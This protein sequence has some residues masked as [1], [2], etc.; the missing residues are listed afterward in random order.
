[1]SPHSDTC[2]P[3]LATQRLTVQ[4]APTPEAQA[5]ARAH[6]G[7]RSAAARQPREAA[8]S[9]TLDPE[10]RPSGRLTAG[11]GKAQRAEPAR[12]LP[13]VALNSATVP[14]DHSEIAPNGAT[15]PRDPGERVA[16][17]GATVPRATGKI[18]PLS[19]ARKISGEES[20]PTGQKKGLLKRT[21]R[22]GGRGPGT[23]AVPTERPRK[24][25]CPREPPARTEPPPSAEGAAPRRAAR[26]APSAV[27]VDEGRSGGRAKTR[28]QRPNGPTPRGTLKQ[29]GK[30]QS[31]TEHSRHPSLPSSARAAQ[32]LSA[33][34]SSPLT[35]QPAAANRSHCPLSV[36]RKD[37]PPAEHEQL[38]W[39]GAGVE[40]ASG[41]P[42]SPTENLQELSV[43]NAKFLAAHG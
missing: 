13:G 39:T 25:R 4:A 21:S 29:A 14:R 43:A 26:V 22:E 3:G 36:A 8:D 16:P 24:S 7:V 10:L 32:L 12:D 5:D 27:T 35:R 20:V 37:T 41:S 18:P 28:G 1:M 40:W 33:E 34:A 31:S 38:D 30:R 42:A 15:V 19:A 9:A 2:C 17:N 6:D 23:P 11:L